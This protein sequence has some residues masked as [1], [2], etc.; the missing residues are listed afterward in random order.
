MSTL[1]ILIDFDSYLVLKSDY[2]QRK[3]MDWRKYS[4]EQKLEVKEEDASALDICCLL[5][6]IDVISLEIVCFLSIYYFQHF[7]CTLP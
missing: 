4:V 3:D 6:R 7:N 5:S 1:K 2:A